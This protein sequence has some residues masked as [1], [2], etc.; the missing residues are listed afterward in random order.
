MM[1]TES[2]HK[3]YKFIEQNLEVG[4]LVHATFDDGTRVIGIVVKMTPPGGF[5]VERVSVTKDEDRH[6]ECDLTR[7]T[8][9]KVILPGE[10]VR[11]FS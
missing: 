8:M 7:V 2:F 3:A 9:L 10:T 1:T 4:P 6:V 11:L 5:V